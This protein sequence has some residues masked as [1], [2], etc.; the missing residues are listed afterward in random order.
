MEMFNLTTTEH[1][2]ATNPAVTVDWEQVFRQHGKKLH[3][4]IRKRVSNHDDVE[5]LKQ[6]TYLE[7]LK[8]KDKFA[9][10]SRPETW[11]FGIALNLVRN[12][13]KQAR[14][15]ANEMGDEL[16][17]HVAVDADP[18]IITES[19]RALKR[20][21]EAM[22][23]LPDDTYQMLLQLLDSDASYQDLAIQLNI[24]IGTV[25]SRLSRARGVIRQAVDA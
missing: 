4:F 3:N 20:A 17:E 1:N 25:R 7:V 19:Q 9:G 24:P 22:S 5:D 11:V 15:R 2:H 23:H 14:Q 21:V 18:G 10:A 8:H 13:F 6:M 12:Y 16:L